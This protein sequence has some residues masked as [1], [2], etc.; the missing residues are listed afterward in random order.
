VVTVLTISSGHSAR[1]L[2]DA[3]ATGRENYY[4]GAVAAGEPPGRWYGSGAESLGLTGLVNTQ[5]MLAL[6]ER[7]LDPREEGFKDPEQWDEVST[8]GHAGRRYLSEDE[9]YARALDAEPNADAERRDALRVQAGKSARKNVA[10]LDATF[11]VQKSVTMLHVAFEAQEVAAQKAGRPEEAAQWAEH[12][13]AVEDAIWAGNRAALDYLTEHAGFSRIGH[14]GGSAGRWTDAHDWTIAS[15]FQHDSRNH[16]P[17]LHI[18]NAIL[19]RVQCP[20]GSWRTLD[21]RSLYR[22]RGAAAAIGERTLEEYLTRVL[23]VRFATRPDGKAREVVGVDFAVNDLQSSRRHAITAKTARLVAVFE[24]KHGRSP[25]GLELDSLQRTATLATRKAKSYQGETDVERVERVDR[26]V[27]AML[28]GGLATVAHEVLAIAQTPPEVQPWSPREVVETALAAVQQKKAGWTIGDLTREISNALPDHLGVADGAEL[29]KLHDE[30]AA[31]AVALADLAV[32]LDSVRPGDADLPDELRLANGE[33]AYQ[34]PG[35]RLYATPEHVH[36]ERM[37]LAT[38]SDATAARIERP[39]AQAFVDRL[40]EAG[41]ELGADQAA[42]VRGVLCSGARIESLVGPAGTGKSFV[43]GTLAKAWTDPQLWDGREQRVFGLAA[44]QVAAEVLAGE[45]LTSANTARWLAAQGRL[46]DDRGG[47]GDEAWRLRDGDLVVVDES[48]MAATTD[49]AAVN[50]RVNAAGAKLLLVGDHR[51]LAAVGAGGAMELLS[52]AGSS[53]ELT[54][55]RRF[56]EEWERAAS[57]QLRAGDPAALDFYHRNGRIRDA[58]TIEQAE[59]AASLAWMSD[60]LAGKHSVLVVDRN[61]QA[62]RICAQVRTDL[63]RLG[64]VE[65]QGVALGRQGTYAG[66]GD[67]VQARRVAW[68]LAGHDG[69]RRGPLNRENFRVV[70]LTE[71]GGLV[72]AAIVGREAGNEVLGER[73]TLPPSYVE[74]DLALGY[75]ATAHAVESMTVDTAHCVVTPNTARRSLYPA[76]TRGRH[77]NT[78]HVVTRSV[79]EQAETGESLDAIHRSP[80]SVLEQI[81]EEGPDLAAQ[82]ATAL[83]NESA[84]DMTAVRTPAELFADGIEV[85]TAGRVSSWL[86]ELV[87]EGALTP[88]QRARLAAEDAAPTLGRV[89]RRAELAEHNPRQVLADAVNERGLDNSRQITNVLHHRIVAGWSLDPVGDSYQQ[90]VPQLDDPAAHRYLESLARTAD[91]R[92]LELGELAAIDPPA[93]AVEA[94]GPPPPAAG[95]ERDD[96]IERAGVVAAHR[97]LSGHDDAEVAIGGPPPAGQSEAYASWRSAWRALG[98]PDA[99]AASDEVALS[100]GR[101]RMRIRAYEREE[102]WAPRY[103][104]NEL[105]GTIQAADSYRDSAIRRAAEAQATTDPAER[106]A[107][108]QAAADASALAEMLDQQAERLRELNDD[109]AVWYLHTAETRAAALRATAELTSRHADDPP[110]D[111]RVTAAQWRAAHDEAMQEEDQHREITD[112]ADLAEFA[113]DDRGLVE[114]EPDIREIVADEPAQ[115]DEDIV[116]VPSADEA[117]HSIWR[118]QRALAEIAARRSADTARE[119]E[120]A[121][122]EQLNRWHAD[123]QANDDSRY[124]GYDGPAMERDSYA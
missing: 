15:F 51:Q 55:A 116:R 104:A 78:M 90:R 54:E 61:E 82:S 56:T 39:Q 27:R 16:D 12:R 13:R 17:Q 9:L 57:L 45:G 66:V 88:A 19:N 64:L 96:W 79:P 3:V 108:E 48:S 105:A 117:A 107:L 24:E 52:R 115:Q 124:S 34:M 35:G 25:N 72:V 91:D 46:A 113:A 106:A 118:A 93:W 62:D 119:A 95:A 42:A 60:T 41:I 44:S 122:A 120:E 8:L 31:E 86:D 10:F 76:A 37:L 58:G 114:V 18:H 49:L 80:H 36:T 109:R 29:A 43:V 94:L 33:S 59:N 123:D 99:E 103:V 83:A 92:R 28:D 5:D 73:L 7:F 22:F 69:N 6:Y 65:E 4:T 11:S 68:E 74:R 84:A 2:T 47:E 23:G 40:A 75:A 38:T 32:G 102:T 1:Y 98:R 14:H 63:V 81:L 71:D 50:E 20:D 89:L 85:F 121:R 101:L 26:E 87:D 70:E 77:A 110:E 100:D 111:D 67:L 97:E 53:H 112:E 30:L 21:G